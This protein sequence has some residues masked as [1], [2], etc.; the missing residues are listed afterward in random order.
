MLRRLFTIAAFQI[1]SNS[2]TQNNTR[3]L[4]HGSISQ[5]SD[6]VLLGSVLR[7]GCQRVEAFRPDDGH[8]SNK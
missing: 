2:A 5:T 1:A 3:L 8:Y 4:A 6:T 7:A